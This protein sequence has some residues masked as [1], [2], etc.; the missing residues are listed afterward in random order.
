[1]FKKGRQKQTVQAVNQCFKQNPEANTLKY[2]KDLQKSS[3]FK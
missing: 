1:M 2:M 3:M